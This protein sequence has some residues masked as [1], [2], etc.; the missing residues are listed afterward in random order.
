MIARAIAEKQAQIRSLQ[1]DIDALQRAKTIVDGRPPTEDVRDS[2]QGCIKADEG[3]LGRQ[4]K[5]EDVAAR[6]TISGARCG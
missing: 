4:A 2:A 1:A 3:L 5:S 6:L